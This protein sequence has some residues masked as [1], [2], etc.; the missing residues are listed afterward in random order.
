ME[1]VQELGHLASRAEN[2]RMRIDGNLSSIK[3]ATAAHFDAAP[4]AENG[5]QLSYIAKSTH[6]CLH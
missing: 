6:D 5:M 3:E 1:N 2:H 4:I